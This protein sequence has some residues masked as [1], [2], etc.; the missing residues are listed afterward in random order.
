MELDR[1]RVRQPVVDHAPRRVRIVCLY[2][3][4]SSRG[5]AVSACKCLSVVVRL[6]DNRCRFLPWFDR[7]LG[8]H[9]AL[10]HIDMSHNT[11]DAA[12]C[13]MIG[14]ALQ[15]RAVAASPAYR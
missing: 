12:D 6:V 14:A 2:S 13:K 7:A 15:V 3:Q 11:L 5:L 1:W 4:T 10:T 9:P 8:D